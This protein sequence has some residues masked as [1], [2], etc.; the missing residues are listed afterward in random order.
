VTYLG[1]IF[2][3]WLTQWLLTLTLQDSEA[4]YKHRVEEYVDSTSGYGTMTE[5]SSDSPM[6]LHTYRAQPADMQY[7]IT[8]FNFT[9]SR[10]CS[11]GFKP[12]RL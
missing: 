3:R 12:T 10:L 6:L 11:V 5:T 9:K 1:I 2:G 4:A 8:M 7:F